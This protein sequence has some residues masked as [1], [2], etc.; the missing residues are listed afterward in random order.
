MQNIQSP[1]TDDRGIEAELRAK[2]KTGPTVTLD[3]IHALI[4]SEH[5]YVPPDTTL[6]I[7]TLVLANGFTVTGESACAD[8]ANFDEA[9]GRRLAKANA[10]NK[11]WPLEGYRLKQD[12]WRASLPQGVLYVPETSSVEEQI[13]RMAHEVNRAYCESL[14]D[15]SQPAWEEAPQWQRDSAIAG[16]KMH[17]ANPHATPKDSHDSWLAQKRADGWQWGPEKDPE[18]KLHP[19]F[20]EY[21]QLPPEQRAKDF[22]FRGVV[23]AMAGHS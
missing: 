6:T 10:V 9:I 8:P 19:C 17:L 2:G 18:R 4:R 7:C 23:R 21:E 1:T 16:A 15:S 14:G 3:G 11:V 12:L 20:V 5:Y 22:L 13:A